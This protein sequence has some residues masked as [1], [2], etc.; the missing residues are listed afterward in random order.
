MVL[1]L[2]AFA[3]ASAAGLSAG[4]LST[5]SFRLMTADRHAAGLYGGAVGTAAFVGS[6]LLLAFVR[7]VLLATV[8]SVF[9]CWAM[10]NERA[11]VTH[12]AFHELFALMPVRAD[13]TTPAEA[14]GLAP[15]GVVL[16]PDG[17]FDY[18]HHQQQQQQLQHGQVG[19][20]YVGQPQPQQGAGPAPLYQATVVQGSKA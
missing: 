17:A 5:G 7:S 6:G 4:L 13:G 9:T 20:V 2:A 14:M 1:G 8:D 3:L 12:E 19:V 15:G 16:Q 10:D 18:A 11:A